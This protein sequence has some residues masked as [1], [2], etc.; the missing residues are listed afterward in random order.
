MAVPAFRS[1]YLAGE[2]LLRR[3]VTDPLAGVA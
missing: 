2:I 3:Y 1:L